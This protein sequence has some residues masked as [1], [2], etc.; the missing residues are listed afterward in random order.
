M[1]Q[2][3]DPNAFPYWQLAVLGETNPLLCGNIW[4]QLTVTSDM[5]IL[6]AHRLQL[7]PR[8]LVRLRH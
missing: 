1:S 8:L 6:R 2:P 7:H 4:R 3:K 5:S